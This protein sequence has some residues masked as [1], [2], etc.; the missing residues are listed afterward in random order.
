MMIGEVD[1]AAEDAK[2]FKEEH[3]DPITSELQEIINRCEAAE[4]NVNQEAA[5][6]QVAEGRRIKVRTDVG[7]SQL[8]A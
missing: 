1:G 2:R 7:M 3:L 5:A 4:E 6:A 8:L